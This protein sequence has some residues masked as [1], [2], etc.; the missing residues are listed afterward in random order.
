MA[1]TKPF[2][3]RRRLTAGFL[4]ASACVQVLA[5]KPVPAEADKLA[6]HPADIAPSAYLYRA[7]RQAEESPPEAWVLLMQHANLPF[8]QPVD[9]KAPAVKQVLCGLLWEEVRPVRRLALSWPARAKNKP[10][11]DQL[12]VSCFDGQDDTAH[13]WWNPRTVKE[14][15]SP[16][17]S[18]DG[19]T[20]SY[21]IPVDTWGVVAAVRGPKEASAFAVPE[22]QAFVC[23]KWMQMDV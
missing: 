2:L 11:P 16:E 13:T 21:T 8:D 6:G 14:V 17:V 18:A 9:T 4:I 3:W 1:D 5:A 23:D 10:A 19:C 7:D 12:V 20:Y 22:L 15:A